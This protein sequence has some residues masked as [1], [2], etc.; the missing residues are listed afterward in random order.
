MES[1]TE[2]QC[3]SDKITPAMPPNMIAKNGRPMIRR[4]PLNDLADLLMNDPICTHISAIVAMKRKEP[5]IVD[6][7]EL[8]GLGLVR[9]GGKVK[10]PSLGRGVV[11]ELY[12]FPDGTKTIR[13]RF[14]LR[15]SKVLAP[16]FARL[17]RRSW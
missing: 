7:M 4:F 3:P 16:E 8:E 12:L 9:P 15:G 6:E 2:R 11:E 14:W 17:R 1:P 5:K 13:V 10:H